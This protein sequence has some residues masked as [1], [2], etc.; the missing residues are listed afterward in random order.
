MC[1]VLVRRVVF[2]GSH[3]G[4]ERRAEGF[5]VDLRPRGLKRRERRDLRKALVVCRFGG[6]GL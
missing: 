5:D 4:T 2:E 6:V 3:E 1:W